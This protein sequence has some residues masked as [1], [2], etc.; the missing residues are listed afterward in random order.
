MFYWLAKL[1]GIEIAKKMRGTPMGC[2]C[3]INFS[4][5]NGYIVNFGG[6][7]FCLRFLQVSFE[8]IQPF[9]IVI[10]HAGDNEINCK[11]HSSARVSKH[12]GIPSLNVCN[13]T[14]I[15]EVAETTALNTVKRSTI[16]V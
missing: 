11:C 4:F 2:V 16:Q 10:V 1:N 8:P 9:I 12:S 5:G 7:L 3:G 6:C 13:A 14:R 15:A